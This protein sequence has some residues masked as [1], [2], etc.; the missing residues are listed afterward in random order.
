MVVYQVLEGP[1]ENV[2]RRRAWPRLWEQIRQDGRHSVLE[3]TIRRRC[4][5]AREFENWSMGL[6]EVEQTA[7]MVPPRAGAG[8]G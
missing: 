1:P 3:D 7:W 6:D 2:E 5:K 4:I 8:W